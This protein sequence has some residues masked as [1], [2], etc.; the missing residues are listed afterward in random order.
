MHGSEPADYPTGS[1]STDETDANRGSRD[2]GRQLFLHGR[3]SQEKRSEGAF[4]HGLERARA[5]I[6][7]R[8]GHQ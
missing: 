8:N 2:T 7:G 6:R 3:R 1:Y 4:C 5:L